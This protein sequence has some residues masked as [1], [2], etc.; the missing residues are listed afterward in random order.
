VFLW[1]EGIKRKGIGKLCY[2]LL[3]MSRDI[4]KDNLDEK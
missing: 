2:C 1:E 3:F 4:G